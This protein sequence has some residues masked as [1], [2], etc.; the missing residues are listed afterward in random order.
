MKS[1]NSFKTTSLS[2]QK[3]IQRRRLLF[4]G[5]AWR[6]SNLKPKGRFAKEGPA[7]F[8]VYRRNTTIADDDNGS[9][10]FVKFSSKPGCVSKVGLLRDKWE[11]VRQFRWRWTWTAARGL[12]RRRTW[13]RD[14]QCR[15]RPFEARTTP[16]RPT[17]QRPGR[18][19]RTGSFPENPA[20]LSWSRAAGASGSTSSVGRT[21]KASS[22]PSFLLEV[23]LISAGNC[24]E[25]IR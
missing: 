14:R 22:S 10:R 15:C 20:P 24:V 17:E 9:K 23:R 18:D 25:E 11:P 19:W 13:R 12:C 5:L 21:P 3:V 16:S 2:V 8:Y 6:E 1:L 7:H 4:S